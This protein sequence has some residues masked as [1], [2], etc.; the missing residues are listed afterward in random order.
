M[1]G[2]SPLEMV[3]AGPS[4]GPKA[5]SPPPQADGQPQAPRG[6]RPRGRPLGGRGPKTRARGPPIAA[7]ATGSARGTYQ[8][9]NSWLRK[10]RGV[11]RGAMASFVPGG[12][13][14][15]GACFG[16]VGRPVNTEHEWTSH[17]VIRWTGM[18][19]A[20]R[21][22]G[23]GRGRVGGRRRSPCGGRST[24][25]PKEIGVPLGAVF[26]AGQEETAVH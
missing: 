26:S 10:R 5:P 2:G 23:R 8:G 9:P 19:L 12:S 7:R 14:V 22:G 16:S 24:P 20:Y 18:C 25:L 1:S 13:C 17:T 3:A 15:T 21:T 6:R 11:R 4:Q